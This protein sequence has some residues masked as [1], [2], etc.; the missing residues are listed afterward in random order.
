MIK[1]L[2]IVFL[3][4][5]A[6]FSCNGEVSG[7]EEPID[8]EGDRLWVVDQPSQ[9]VIFKL[10]G[11]LLCNV[12]G[13]PEFIKP[14]GV[15]IYRADGSAWVID[16]YA[17]TLTKFDRDGNMLFQTTDGGEPTLRQ[18]TSLAVNQSDGSVWVADYIHKRV[19][20]FDEEGEIIGTVKGFTYPRSVSLVGHAGDCW[21][22]DVGT[23]SLYLFDGDL[24]GEA[25]ISDAE[26]TVPGFRTPR[27]VKALT[28]G[29]CWVLDIGNGKIIHIGPGGGTVAT[30]TGFGSPTSLAFSPAGDRV[31]VTDDYYDAIFTVDMAVT[32]TATLDAVGD[33]FITDIM[34]PAHISVDRA[35]EHIFVSETGE[36]R[37][38]EYD[39]NTKEVVIEYEPLEGPVATA[40][41]TD[42]N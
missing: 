2:T 7:P 37:V 33:V 40:I 21:V 29:G 15:D 17:N 25:N 5:L 42:G 41:F 27:F 23:G 38:V 14:N 30:V 32:G 22:S 36:N 39:I 9:I 4:V 26:L 28:D 13:F 12:G 20:R 1:W 8:T 6:L 3:A 19:V 31:F 16:F 10:D 34:N 35:R 24:T 18:P 11:T